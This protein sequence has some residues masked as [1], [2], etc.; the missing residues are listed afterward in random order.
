LSVKSSAFQKSIVGP[1]NKQTKKK[2][3]SLFSAIF[4]PLKLGHIVSDS[5]HNLVWSSNI[6]KEEVKNMRKL[7]YEFFNIILA[8]L[9]L[10]K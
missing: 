2:D 9:E 3:F 8:I 10:I 1:E 7:G 6:K 5:T 4:S